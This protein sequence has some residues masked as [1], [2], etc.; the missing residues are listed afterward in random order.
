MPGVAYKQAATDDVFPENIIVRLLLEALVLAPAVA[1]YFLSFP[2][3]TP[4]PPLPPP[5][6]TCGI[7][8]QSADPRLC[9]RCY[10][11]GY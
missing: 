4:P 11:D 5:P 3:L 6:V 2:A 1:T 10:Y 7:H 8:I 9:E